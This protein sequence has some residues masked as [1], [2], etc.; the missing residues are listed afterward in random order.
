MSYLTSTIS[1]LVLEMSYLR[2]SER[3]LTL[4]TLLYKHINL[5]S[6]SVVLPP[7][8]PHRASSPPVTC[9][10]SPAHFSRSSLSTYSHTRVS[11]DVEQ[12]RTSL[13]G[14]TAAHGSPFYTSASTCPHSRLWF[15]FRARLIIRGCACWWGSS[16]RLAWRR[17]FREDRTR[18]WASGSPS[19][20]RAPAPRPCYLPRPDP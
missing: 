4:Q 20:A 16:W 15:A 9:R 11:N 10:L 13:Q 17:A 3:F 12:K 18:A 7:T 2:P 8:L 14:H 1:P 5:S 6:Y 19:R